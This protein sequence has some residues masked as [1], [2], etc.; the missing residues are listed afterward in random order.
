[1]VSPA[2]SSKRLEIRGKVNEPTQ[3]T[4]TV[5]DVTIPRQKMMGLQINDRLHDCPGLTN[6]EVD[7]TVFSL[8]ITILT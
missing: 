3:I 5:A 4:E 2:K 1:M 7:V 6:F 8:Q